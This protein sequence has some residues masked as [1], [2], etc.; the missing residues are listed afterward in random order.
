MTKIHLSLIAGAS[1]I[2]AGAVLL[3]P[4][5]EAQQAAASGS[6]HLPIGLRCVVTLDPRA[7]KASVLGTEATKKTG[8]SPERAVEGVLVSID[9]EWLIVKDGTYES[10]IPRD[11]VLFLRAS[12]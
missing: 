5:A 1:L 8:M 12:R 2:A 4:S 11:K 6:V 9:A 7:D 3:F 10:W